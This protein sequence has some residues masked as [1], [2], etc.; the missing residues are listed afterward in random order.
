M[1]LFLPLRSA[2]IDRPAASVNSAGSAALARKTILDQDNK[3]ER[4]MNA[5]PNC[6]IEHRQAWIKTSAAGFG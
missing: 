6:A 4:G 5:G 1:P 3:R 2:S